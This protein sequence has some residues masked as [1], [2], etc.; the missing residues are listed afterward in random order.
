MWTPFWLQEL[1]GMVRLFYFVPFL[2]FG[3]IVPQVLVFVF[4]FLN[5]NQYIKEF[6]SPFKKSI[7][8][9]IMPCASA[10]LLAKVKQSKSKI[11]T[12]NSL[13]LISR[14]SWSVAMYFYGVM[15]PD[16]VID[17]ALAV[18]AALTL[19]MTVSHRS[20][21]SLMAAVPLNLCRY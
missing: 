19:S 8:F 21:Q 2:F 14:V 4:S 16:V 7:I 17:T 11:F 9:I 12:N 13:N 15:N 10:R 20:L 6:H 1:L 3:T 18:Q 5:I